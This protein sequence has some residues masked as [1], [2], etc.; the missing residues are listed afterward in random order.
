[1][2]AFGIILVPRREIVLSD[3]AVLARAVKR[4]KS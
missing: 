1:M 4:L 3:P 2:F